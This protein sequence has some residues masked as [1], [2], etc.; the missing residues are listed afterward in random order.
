LGTW[1]QQ[2]QV[3]STTERGCGS[4]ITALPQKF[5][6]FFF[7]ISF[8]SFIIGGGLMSLTGRE[9]AKFVTSKIGTPYVYGAKGA[10]GPFTKSKFDWLCRNYPKVFTATYKN[11]VINKGLIGKVCTDCSGLIS[12]YTGKILGSAQL[13][14][15]A[16]AR[17]PM[18]DYEKFAVGT[19]LYRQGHVGVYIGKNSKGKHVVVEAKGIDYG[20]V[21]NI[22]NP[23][24]WTC[25]LTFDWINYNIYNP[26]EP[27][28]ISYRCKNPYT[29]PRVL[30]KLGATG[31][32]V[33]WLQYELIE[34]GFGVR[35]SYNHKA[36]DPII[37]SGTFDNNTLGAVL[38]FQSS[39]K[40]EVDGIVGPVTRNK[41][42]SDISNDIP[43]GK[44]VYPEPKVLLKLG[45]KGMDVLWLQT[46]LCIKGYNVPITGIFDSDLS[47]IVRQFQKDNKLVVD[48]IVGRLTRTALLK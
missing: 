18:S 15:K 39:C 14:S 35:F 12:W 34:A 10:D 16:Y 47:A 19:I 43:E 30:L 21:A 28:K 46:Q 8:N 11:K 33:K 7:F 38:A 40:V 4:N 48:G 29:E 5:N 23:A 22:V 9:L 45:S 44:N 36:Y 27:K 20:T 26:I 25:G 42:S 6:N 41:L 2:H 37:I 17:L 3:P 31:D 24:K 1:A 13:Y 32:G